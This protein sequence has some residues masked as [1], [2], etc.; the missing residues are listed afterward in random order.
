MF[1]IDCLL[2]CNDYKDHRR[3]WGYVQYHDMGWYP[4]VLINL[5]RPQYVV[6]VVKS[7]KVL[8]TY[9]KYGTW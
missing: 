9:R 6:V 8:A 4:S 1:S 7:L 3:G 2:F 5:I